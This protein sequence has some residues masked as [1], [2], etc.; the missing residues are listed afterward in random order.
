M[1]LLKASIIYGILSAPFPFYDQAYGDFYRKV[2]DKCF[3]RFRGPGF[4]KFNE[5][6]DPAMT[7]VNVGNYTMALPDGSFDTAAIDINT[8]Y[9]GYLPT[10]LLISLVL[11]SPV[12][13]KRR[14][15]ALAIGLS[16]VMLL[17]LFKHWISLLWFCEQNVWLHLTDFT[18]TGKKV[19]SFANSFISA[20]SFTIA[21]F[22]VGIWLLVTFRVDDLKLNKDT[23]S[24]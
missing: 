5:M 4:A 20:S 8:R 9:L 6:K 7:H 22:V 17:I 2:A 14:L 19:L 3:G 1:F 11:A 18:G 10:I 15:I 13:W 16:L 12:P 23:K 21:Y 24:V